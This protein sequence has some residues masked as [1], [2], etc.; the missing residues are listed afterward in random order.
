ML[1]HFLLSPTVQ[2]PFLILAKTVA[3]RFKT[4]KNK[5]GVV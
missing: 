2:K 5:I 4:M 3:N 1:K